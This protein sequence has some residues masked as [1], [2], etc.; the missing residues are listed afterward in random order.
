[1]AA[2]SVTVKCGGCGQPTV[3]PEAGPVSSCPRC[4][5]RQA[6]RVLEVREGWSAPE[7]EHV[8]DD[9]VI[10]AALAPEGQPCVDCGALVLY[11]DETGWRHA[12]TP[13]A[14]CWLGRNEP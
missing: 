12:E 14:G 2:V 8:S 10:A 11:S 7:N 9:A 5:R 1:V 4:D 3:M 6:E 13:P